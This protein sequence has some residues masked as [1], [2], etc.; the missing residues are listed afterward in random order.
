MRKSKMNIAIIMFVLITVILLFLLFVEVY[1][2]H[3]S[4]QEA[5][6]EMPLITIENSTEQPETS[7]EL[8]E[9]TTELPEMT[10]EA[11]K[12]LPSPPD[13]DI[14]LND[15]IKSFIYEKCK[16]DDDMYCLVMAVIK[17]E[18]DF[19]HSCVSDD[20][21]DRG[22]MQLRD[23]YYD[24]WIKKYDVTDPEELYDNLTVGITMLQE[25]I[26]KYEYKNLALMSYNC[27]E[28]GA[29]RLWKKDIYNTNYTKK[30]LRYYEAYIEEVTP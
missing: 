10:T 22:L 25:Y 18:S 2:K 3:S 15:E 9:M 6:T 5:T 8:P 21:H 24:Y 27:G 29:K 30:V 28:T 17:Q 16:Y 1:A 19:D 4:N 23:L 12:T 26:E 14:P 7:T 13:L 20:G 11:E